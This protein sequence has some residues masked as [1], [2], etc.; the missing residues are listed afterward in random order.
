MAGEDT[1]HG[2]GKNHEQKKQEPKKKYK[3]STS[4]ERIQNFNFEMRLDGTMEIYNL[5]FLCILFLLFGF[6]LPFFFCSSVLLFF[7]SSVDLFIC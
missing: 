5:R 2:R 7:C 1:S 6:L 3:G 4:K